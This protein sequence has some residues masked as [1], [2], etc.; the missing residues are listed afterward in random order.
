MNSATLPSRRLPTEQ[1]D[2]LRMLGY[3]YLQ[4]GQPERALPLFRLLH[5]LDPQDR[6]AAES[7]ACTW[8]RLREA[9]EALPILDQLVREE[10]PTAL[11]WLLRGQALTLLGRMPEA[12]RSMRLFV[13]MRREMEKGRAS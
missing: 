13:T 6:H 2:L 1:R 3:A 7:L 12:A 5:L 8:L 11:T 9:A 4:N 10:R